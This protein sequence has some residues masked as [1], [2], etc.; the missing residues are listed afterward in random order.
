MVLRQ[1]AGVRVE[2]SDDCAQLPVVDAG[3]TP[4]AE[5]SRRLAL[6]DAVADNWGVDRRRAEGNT[7]WF[8]CHAGNA[9][10]TVGDSV[11]TAVLGRRDE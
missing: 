7:V 10:A 11:E 5:G 4:D 9:H 2:V 1:S 8:E 3:F 6:L